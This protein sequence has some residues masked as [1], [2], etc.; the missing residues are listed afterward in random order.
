MPYVILDNNRVMTESNKQV[1]LSNVALDI[2]FTMT[3]EAENGDYPY[4]W[5]ITPVQFY[6]NNNPIYWNVTGVV[7]YTGR[8]D[9]TAGFDWNYLQPQYATNWNF[10]TPGVKIITARSTVNDVTRIGFGQ[11]YGYAGITSLDISK[12]PSLGFMSID[13]QHIDTTNLNI[14]VDQLIAFNNTSGTEFYATG[15]NMGCVTQA[16]KDALSAIWTGTISVNICP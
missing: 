14:I 9:G 15:P 5:P 16:K 13:Y 11:N 4:S 3:T 2:L 7:S 12:C 8:T 6:N 1:S 10:S